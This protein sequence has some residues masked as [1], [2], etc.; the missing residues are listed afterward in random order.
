MSKRAARDIDLS[1]DP[2]FSEMKRLV[3]AKTGLS[4]YEDKN[5][6]LARILAERMQ[7]CRLGDCAAYAAF[8]GRA[9]G[10]AEQDEL[11]S[12]LTIGETY[13][14]RHPE[15]F[16]ALKRHVV[17]DILA[18]NTPTRRLKI[19]SAGCSTGAEPYSIAIL[20]KRDFEFALAGWQGSVIGT[21]ID[22]RSLAQAESGLYQ[23]WALRATPEQERGQYFERTP[24]GWCLKP[25]YREAVRFLGHNLIADALPAP[26][27][28]L[29][30]I[31][32]ILCRNVAIYFSRDQI[33]R[34]MAR[35][36]ASLND[37]GWLITG[38]A[39]IG[40]DRPDG[41]VPVNL[42]GLIVYR[43][44]QAQD[45]PD[46][47]VWMPPELPLAAPEAFDLLVNP[48]VQS[49]AVETAQ[50]TAEMADEEAA[51]LED[52]ALRGQW[53]AALGP[54]RHILARPDAGLDMTLKAVQVLIEAGDFDGADRALKRLLFVD[55]K[56]LM[57]YYHQ[58]ILLT[59]QGDIKMAA[60]AFRNARDLA[61]VLPP[62]SLLPGGEGLRA[63]QLAAMAALR[64][65]TETAA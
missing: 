39:E 38:P 64:A 42:D 1:Q 41:F 23:D 10:R 45:M 18:R 33:Q 9:E 43:K 61:A 28:G 44:G 37:G 30:D 63:G 56:C 21:D 31:D 16:E 62:D 65:R 54:A 51:Q 27:I 6:E 52:L 59:C 14:F 32:V 26:D 13:F 8:L 47:H 24:S 53:L 50:A 3:I 7:A 22:R 29:C 46:R 19:W 20:L 40:M 25:R 5:A 49:Q 58:G 35:F 17:P 36:H 11:I 4:Y 55:R 34:L 57:A 15:V 48:L 2:G 60:K 12:E